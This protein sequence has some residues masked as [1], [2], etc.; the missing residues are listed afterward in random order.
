[1]VGD[2]DG[3]GTVTPG[4]VRGTTWYLRNANSGGAANIAFAYGR[5]TDRPVVGD[6]DGNGTVTPGIVRGT[7]WFLRKPNTGGPAD[8]SLTY[9]A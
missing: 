7:T 1:M 6:W 3:N 4:I 5:S 8:I 2:W 9:A